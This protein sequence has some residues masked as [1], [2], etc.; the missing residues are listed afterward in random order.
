MSTEEEGDA[1]VLGGIRVAADQKEAP[2]GMVRPCRQIFL[3][4][5]DV[6][7]A[8]ADGAGLESSEVAPAPGSL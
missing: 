1:L 4:V 7:I 2:V 6:V 8:I 3:T 5:D